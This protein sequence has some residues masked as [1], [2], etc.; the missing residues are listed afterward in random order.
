MSLSV[1]GLLEACDDPRLFAFP[2]WPV[3]REL[4]ASIDA[5][6]R[7]QVMALGR[8]A[9][10]TTLMALTCLHACLLRPELL[11]RVRRGE[12]AYAVG[13]ATNLRQSRLLVAAALSVVEAS[14]LLAPMVESATDDE[15]RFRNGT[16]LTAFPCTARGG[17]GGAIF[18]ACFDEFAHFVDSEGNS[19]AEAVWRA[20]VPS[21]AQFGDLAR[22]VVGSTPFGSAGAF[23]ELFARAD[24][25]E[26]P[27][28]V[29]F[30]AS[31][32]EV[33][34]TLDGRFLEGELLLLGEEGFAGEYLADF[35]G[36]GGSFLDPQTIEDAVADRDGLAPD[37]ASGWVAGLDPAFSSD[38]FGLALVA[39]DGGR[40][41]LGL[42]HSWRPGRVRAASFEERRAVE[43]ALL[44]EVA[45]V[46][47]SYR[48]R[49]VTD[50]YAAPAIV[51]RLQRRGLRVKTVPMTATSKTDAYVELRARLNLGQL[52]LYRHPELLAELR[53]L[54][55][56]F[57][58]GSASVVNP[59]VG[60]SHGDIA[61]A[62]ALAVSELHGG[63]VRPARTSVA[64][65]RIP[66][67]APRRDL[68]GFRTFNDLS[69]SLTGR[70]AE[71]SLWVP[72]GHGFFLRSGLDFSQEKPP[73]ER[74]RAK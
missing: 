20:L 13:V 70:N 42:A 65:G 40:L 55:S 2:L 5:G 17:R 7:L 46:C 64:R 29:A 47:L 49:V 28:A 33:N 8:R 68:G 45:D 9:S 66:T 12:R 39:K 67:S 14:P 38:P 52:E 23:A 41:V 25:G 51:D 24:S 74:R 6:P 26:L 58:A 73:G 30:R 72:A 16:A 43:D 36:S 53:R 71:T 18:C 15:I 22:V 1:V 3:Q 19:A 62:L 27:D 61:Q 32:A 56:K 31:S 59:R 63:E 34:P 4:F 11:E 50:Q 54:R 21:T 10:K 69:V 57:T 37:Q 44:D 60:G 48:A 35:V